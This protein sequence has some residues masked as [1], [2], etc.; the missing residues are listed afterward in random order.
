VRFLKGRL[1][2]FADAFMWVFPAR[3]GIR[4][5]HR[6]EG[7]YE[8]SEAD[9]LNGSRFPDDVAF[10]A[11]PMEV[12]ET[13]RGPRFQFPLENRPCGIPLRSLRALH[14]SLARGAGGRS[15]DGHLLCHWRGGRESRRSFYES[16]NQ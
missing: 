12:R 6:V 5:G 4:E 13:A 3:L 1:D 8:L 11:W 16:R 7:L 14:F 9:I 2:F 15:G 10:S